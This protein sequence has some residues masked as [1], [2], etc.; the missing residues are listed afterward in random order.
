MNCNVW[1]RKKDHQFL[2][3][4]SDGTDKW[5]IPGLGDIPPQYDIE[6]TRYRWTYAPRLALV[7]RPLHAGVAVFFETVPPRT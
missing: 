6:E 5:K 4:S 2:R 1:H 7:S 3:T